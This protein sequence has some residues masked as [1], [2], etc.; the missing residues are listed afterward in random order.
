MAKSSRTAP[1]DKTAAQIRQLQAARALS[2]LV[3]PARE[4]DDVDALAMPIVSA[5]AFGAVLDP[6]AMDV[7]KRLANPATASQRNLT[8]V[9][10]NRKPARVAAKA[11]QAKPRSVTVTAVSPETLRQQVAKR[12][13]AAA[14]ALN[15]K[16]L[17]RQNT[18]QSKAR[19]Q[20]ALRS[21]IG[22]RFTDPRVRQQFM[23]PGVFVVL[24]RKAPSMKT[25]ET[26]QKLLLTC[27]HTAWTG[28]AAKNR[29][30]CA[31]C[32]IGLPS[33][34][35]ALH[36][37]KKTLAE[38]AHRQQ[39]PTDLKAA[40]RIVSASK[41]IGAKR[42]TEIAESA[43]YLS[44]P[45]RGIAAVL[46]PGA[47]DKSTSNVLLSCG[48]T[49]NSK[50]NGAELVACEACL[51]KSP[52]PQINSVFTARELAQYMARAQTFESGPRAIKIVPLSVE[53]AQDPVM[54]ERHAL[55]VADKDARTGLVEET[56]VIAV[57]RGASAAIVAS[58]DD[59]Y[60][61]VAA[62]IANDDDT[63][64][65]TRLR[66][67]YLTCGHTI[68]TRATGGTRVS[69]SKCLSG[70]PQDPI[71]PSVGKDELAALVA[72]AIARERSLVLALKAQPHPPPATA[73][74]AA[75]NPPARAV[76]R[77]RP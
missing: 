69:C 72:T 41:R 66:Q 76:S 5:T 59:Q 32:A 3:P 62:Y 7:A 68:A 44:A 77:H 52:A 21:T 4:P 17:E 19:L 64:L 43:T 27:G 16:E 42:A 55:R 1:P 15:Q 71:P 2:Y 61:R 34:T 12:L 48:H 58:V 6:R 29:I 13:A 35:R 28:G 46:A 30:F 40:E 56:R 39:L 33:D 37:K 47:T 14:E 36:V 8:V 53:D 11:T 65:G 75:V 63:R 67:A 10:M 70:A 54:L 73:T 23:R 50:S 60:L 57:K 22:E 31:K 49:I 24:E 45:L 74:L 25:G 26:L 20:P 38:A 18:N 9:T 51:A